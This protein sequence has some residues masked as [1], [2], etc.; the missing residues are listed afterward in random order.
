MT[1][2]RDKA[3]ELA[4]RGLK[5]IRDKR[6]RNYDQHPDALD[7][8][9]AFHSFTRVNADAWEQCA[10]T[11]LASMRSKGITLRYKRPPRVWRLKVLKRIA[12]RIRWRERATKPPIPGVILVPHDFN[13][14]T[15]MRRFGVI[16]HEMAH[17]HQLR[18]LGPITYTQLYTNDAWRFAMETQA[19]AVQL[20]ATA[21]ASAK[22]PEGE[23]DGVDRAWL[24]RYAKGIARGL[25]SKYV[26]AA[27]GEHVYGHAIGVF[28]DA[29]AAGFEA[30]KP[31]ERR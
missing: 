23:R 25:K 4:K 11:M 28:N 16:V 18:V 29:I 6:P 7:F 9:R 22:M 13:A 14:Q 24:R 15:P 26:L 30:A 19:F 10:E 1:I 12:D 3:L 17:D 31:P 20:A 2:D 21:Y 27:K 8:A 5:L